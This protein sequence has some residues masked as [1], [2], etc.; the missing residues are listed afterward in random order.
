[1][2]ALWINDIH[3]EFLDEPKARRFMDDLKNQG[4]DCI[5]VGGDIAQAPSLIRSLCRLDAEL[6][7][8]I[9]FVLGNHDYYKG[10]I[11][12][13]RSSIAKLVMRSNNLHW[14]NQSGVVR[15]TEST[16][17]IGHDGWAD[18]RLGD[19]YNS[20]V[21]LND[22]FLIKELF[23]IFKETKNI[24]IYKKTLLKRLNNLGDEAADHFRA[25]LPEALQFSN[26]VIVLTHVPPFMEAAWHDG[27]YS[28]PDYLPFF[29]CK[30][31]G[32]V[33]KEMMRLNPRK[34]MTVLCGHTHGGGISHI[35]SNL[36][37]YTGP[38]KYGNPCIQRIFNL[39]DRLSDNVFGKARRSPPE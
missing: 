17:L 31:V 38:A 7:C 26:H 35:L 20:E 36:V 5:L 11:I 28:G 13:V 21:Q 2:R 15:L 9:Y 14:L 33:L 22:F 6:Q 27:R 37:S 24:S 19:Y 29:S 18:G 3:L 4:S 23:N 30:I 8:P 25:I 39:N 16:A 32:D 12:E 1:M 10:S 34:K